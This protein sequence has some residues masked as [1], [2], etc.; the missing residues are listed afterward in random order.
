MGAIEI[1]SNSDHE[2]REKAESIPVSN[3]GDNGK[4]KEVHEDTCDKLE[5]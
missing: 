3:Q 1:E 2:D 4:S 5:S